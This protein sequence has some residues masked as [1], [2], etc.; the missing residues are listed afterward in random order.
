[1]SLESLL[2]A[3]SQGTLSPQVKA[4][5]DEARRRG[6]IGG[7]Q[8]ALQPMTPQDLISI[9]RSS[10]PEDQ[11]INNLKKGLGSEVAGFGRAGLRGANNASLE[12]LNVGGD[13]METFDPMNYATKVTDY[14][15]E[16]IGIRKPE[17]YT[18]E[19]ELH[20][21][22]R[23]ANPGSIVNAGV[24]ALTDYTLDKNPT[25]FE[26]EHSAPLW[27]T[28][29]G[30]TI[31]PSLGELAYGAGYYAPEIA[32]GSSGPAKKA[33]QIAAQRFSKTG[34]VVSKNI[35]KAVQSGAGGALGSL[36]KGHPEEAAINALAFPIAELG[37]QGLGHYAKQLGKGVRKAAPLLADEAG[38]LR[39]GKLNPPAPEPIETL[40]LQLESLV[41]GKS[42]AVLVTPG[43]EM[44]MVP[45]G[46]KKLQSEVGTWIYDPKKLKPFQIKSK[47]FKNEYGEL[48]GH[49]EP[50]SES[51]TQVV[52]ALKNGV[53]AKSSVTSPNNV[54][55]QAKVLQKQFP[56][57]DIIAGNEPLAREVVHA[58][59]NKAPSVQPVDDLL[60][61]GAVPHETQP[62][63]PVGST[64]RGF[65]RTVR[66]SPMSP[67][68]LSEGVSGTY[69]PITNKG[70]LE[71]AQRIVQENPLQARDKILSLK[72]ATAEDYAVGMELI[73]QN[74]AKG[75]FGESIRIANRMAEL[76]TEQG[77]A[78][79]ALSMYN[80][81]GPEGMLRLATK[82][83]QEARANAPK[84]KIHK[85]DQEVN[86]VV[87]F[88]QEQGQP[89]VNKD[90]IREE[91]AKKLK[92]PNISEEFA[93]DITE[94][95][96]ALQAMPEGRQQAL[97]TAGLLRDIAEQVPSP[98]LRKV[99]TYQTIAHLW[100]PK[101]QVRNLVG[102]AAFAAGENLKDV[103]AAPIDRTLSLF[104]KQRTKSLGGLNQLKAQAKGF[105]SGLKEGAQ[106]AWHGVDLTR[107]ADKWEINA[108][109]NGLPRGRTFRGKIMG[110]LERTLG[111]SLRAPDR[112]F[113]KAG[114]EKSLAEQMKLAGVKK[115]TPEMISKAHFEG[116]YKTFQDDSVAAKV[117]TGIKRSLNANKEF[118]VGD[119][120]IKYPKTPGNLLSRSIEYSPAGI[121]KSLM[122]VGKA[123][124]GHGFDQKQF[125]DS[126]AR[127]IVGTGGLTGLG[128]VLSD[129]GL[130]RNTAPQDPKLRNME[131][132]EGLNQSQLN[133]SGLVRWITSGFDKNAAKIRE[134]D[135]LATYDWAVPLSVPV[136][137]GARMQETGLE[138]GD[139]GLAGIAASGLEGGL[140]T[141]GDQPLI[142]T[143]TQLFR[144]KELPDALIEASKGIP[145]SFTPTLLKQ[146]NQVSD[147]TLRDPYDANP[148]KMALNLAINK[149]PFAS[150]LPAK[151][152][153]LGE[154]IESFQGGTNSIMNV[155]F[156]PA[157]ISKYKPAPETKIVLDLYRN[158]S[159]NRIMPILMK[160]KI[161]YRG[162]DLHLNAK[163]KNHVQRVVG[164]LTK[165][166]LAAL[167][168]NEEFMG[169]SDDVKL[170]YLKNQMDDMAD[171]AKLLSFRYVLE[172]MPKDER[173]PYI[174]SYF[175]RNDLSANQK[176]EF[177]K[178]LEQ[179][180]DLFEESPPNTDNK[181][182]NNFE[183]LGVR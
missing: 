172:D 12:A 84:A 177:M 82:T 51:A 4:A 157:F 109:T 86:K 123:A 154:D 174:L 36:A 45:Q 119:I 58:R 61:P 98:L 153:Q 34:P 169:M 117:F 72:D 112:A 164:S 92:L 130:L 93:K 168:K 8:L 90:L 66:E 142:K 7:N 41:K 60:P 178:D 32:L 83:V 180:K 54:V 69:D 99:S 15:G 161:K 179:L 107:I 103:V 144:G 71:S 70:T 145:A 55:A 135:A 2:Q 131:R 75:D 40:N 162:I 17:P 59:F 114:V 25:V 16:S 3:E 113:Y 183:S 106:E 105:A 101:T 116:L 137:M 68:Q 146:I 141:L 91:I 5:L 1:M 35:G 175:K 85:L 13:L 30:T 76:A 49:I 124:T 81:L 10:A 171:F 159:D 125:V 111:V 22:L 21:M 26:K 37:G 115:A 79:Q 181:N 173:V 102:N 28:K 127:A 47:V 167:A 88:L 165:E 87:S 158:T 150:H 121:V 77:Q 48:L 11:T 138:L 65:T 110:N 46:F 44:P 20:N 78:I 182:N 118:G 94:R 129:I 24:K 19:A 33:G 152:N 9:G 52:T 133:V 73:R 143:F 14:L 62:I 163:Q 97:M 64:E 122:E 120:L 128:Y 176:K 6:L 134:G 160:N 29:G 74:N 139:T 27:Q 53:E 31:I 147:N 80:R 126:T 132:M 108:L 39:I 155:M 42:K 56:D 38:A 149:T 166:G 151:V 100:N 43:S 140:E 156:N 23:K 50:K 136:S 104:T 67:Q 89:N 18:M 63:P 57:A 96:T 148:A 95:A 170:K